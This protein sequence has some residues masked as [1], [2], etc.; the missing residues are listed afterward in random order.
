MRQKYLPSLV[1]II[2]TLILCA[3]QGQL[4][5]PKNTLSDNDNLMKG[6]TSLS[7]DENQIVAL[8]AQN[9][10]SSVT[11]QRVIEASLR[12][13]RL[14]L[15]D[16]K[17]AAVIAKLTTASSLE[18]RSDDENVERILLLANAYEGMGN[19]LQALAYFS[20]S[21]DHSKEP[22]QD[23][24]LHIWQLLHQLPFATL[25]QLEQDETLSTVEKGWM[26]LALIEAKPYD[27]NT[28]HQAISNWIATYPN[29]P[30]LTFIDQ[31]QIAQPSPT[32]KHISLLLPLT[33]P[34]ASSGQAVRN[35]FFAAYYQDQLASQAAPSIS[36]LDTN[37]N[38]VSHLYQEA[39][40]NGSDYV[41]GPLL[42]D[43]VNEI[44]A[45][46]ELSIPV[47]AL[48]NP[49]NSEL[50]S[51]FYSFALSPVQEAIATASYAF[52]QHHSP[53]AVMIVPGN[54]WGM[55]IS[56]A[57]QKQWEQLGGQVISTLRYQKREDLYQSIKQL[58]GL[59]LSQNRI[60][61][62]E[63]TLGKKVRA[64]PMI[65][66]DIDC[67]FVVATPSMVR[68]IAPLLKFYY[69][70]SI[71]TYTTSTIYNGIQN[72]PADND[73]DGLIF[74]DMP[75][76]VLK[77]LPP[78]YAYPTIKSQL[79]TL[80]PKSF[81]E[82]IKLYALGLDAYLLSQE[83]P[84]LSITPSLSIVGATG[85]LTLNADQSISRQ[86]LWVQ[87]IDGSTKLL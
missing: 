26:S 17:Y 20:Q 51:N 80:Y 70:G 29:H 66:Q 6:N 82:N 72:T 62:L 86:L 8:S 18:N 74:S 28:F 21:Y 61:S 75:F 73:M 1:V 3:C 47:L 53:H 33:G 83:L 40:A 32:P 9:A 85:N 44:K 57:F 46:H 7:V 67:L 36:V 48:N 30:A 2:S 37:Q 23:L 24:S 11:D 38:D 15:A 84:K 87:M 43:N 34:F 27:A 12:Q 52:L 68:Q 5:L 56:D 41:V 22:S 69:A 77:N 45:L 50:K 60:Q 78:S 35:A 13:A 58:L 4:P 49:S 16:K 55:P 25:N 65:R 76:V 63:N 14:N 79:Q 54:D 19:T 39:I 31:K 64:T 81:M 10:M 42:K 59:D 71:P